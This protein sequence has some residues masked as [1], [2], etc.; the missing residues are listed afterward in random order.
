VV[1]DIETARQLLLSSS[2]LRSG[3]VVEPYLADAIDLNISVRGHGAP[4]LSEIERPIRESKAHFYSYQDKYLGAEG[5]MGAPRELPAAI[6]PELAER[7]R[8]YAATVAQLAQVRGVAR[9]DFLLHQEQLWIN[10]INTIPGAMS[11]YLWRASGVSH[12]TLLTEMLEEAL[13]YPSYEPD[14]TG[15]D[16]LALR[17]AGSIAS[18]LA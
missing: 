9:V 7:L 5:L 2:A 17:N 12:E 4:P 14:A 10:E 15:A 3:A 16:G 11:F 6:A 1:E 18:K 8:G 13:K